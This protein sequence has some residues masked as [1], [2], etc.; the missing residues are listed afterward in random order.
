[1]CFK[2]R[3]CLLSIIEA[4]QLYKS[5]QTLAKDNCSLSNSDNTDVLGAEYIV[6]LHKRELDLFLCRSLG[7]H[8]G[9]YEEF[10]LLGYNA[11]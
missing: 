3:L 8:S 5:Q 7:S 4:M 9:G 1:V 11:M 6:C 2:L 10:C